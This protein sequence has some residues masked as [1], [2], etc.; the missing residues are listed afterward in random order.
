M[1]RRWYISDT[2]FDHGNIL[3]FFGKDGNRIRPEFDTV[4]QM[5]EA[6]IDRWNAVVKPDD[7]VV[8]LGDI[9]MSNPT[10]LREIM[11]KLNGEKI[12]VK[13][14]HDRLK[15]S[16]YADIFRDVRSFIRPNH[17]KIVFTHIPLHPDS[18]PLFCINVH[19]HIH[20]KTVMAVF[21]NEIPDLKYLNISVERTDYTPVSNEWIIEECNKR[22][23]IA[24]E[25][26]NEVIAGGGT[27]S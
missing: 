14:N 16:V 1:P 22:R 13:G 25:S 9:A 12:L 5:N 10:R 27:L 26:V 4:E 3:K 6:M 21:S 7:T 17:Q 23:E 8:H 2:H 18:V 15:L 19:G 11:N 20:E 24:Y